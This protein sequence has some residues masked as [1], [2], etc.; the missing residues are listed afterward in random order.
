MLWTYCKEEQFG[1][2]LC[3]FSSLLYNTMSFVSSWLKLLLFLLLP[4][5]SIFPGNNSFHLVCPTLMQ[6]RSNLALMKCYYPESLSTVES[7]PRAI[8]WLSSRKRHIYISYFIISPG[9]ERGSS[10]LS[11][12]FYLSPWI[13]PWGGH[14]KA[15]RIICKIR[16][17]ILLWCPSPN[18]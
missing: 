1:Y 6:S 14:W 10:E 2:F 12:S 18:I 13:A 8:T 9:C 11:L 3:D 7:V 5:P 16:G 15:G 17:G 4:V